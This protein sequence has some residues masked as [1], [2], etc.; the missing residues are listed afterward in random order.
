MRPGS[1][2]GDRNPESRLLST[3]APG[4]TA[5]VGIMLY[6]ADGRSGHRHLDGDGAFQRNSLDVF[7]I[8]TPH[9][10]GRL[11]KIRVWHDN[12]GGAIARLP[13]PALPVHCPPALPAHCL[14]TARWP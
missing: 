1:A 2:S 11:W 5:H 8:A 14:P 6:G 13:C 3:C 10:L 9:S 12:K 7:Q 4:T